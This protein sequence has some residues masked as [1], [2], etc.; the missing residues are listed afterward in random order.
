MN[1][2]LCLSRVLY[3][4]GQV[5]QTC[6]RNLR[7]H[8]WPQLPPAAVGQS[9]TDTPN[10]LLRTPRGERNLERWTVRTDILPIWEPFH[11]PREER[12]A[13]CVF[14][15]DLVCADC[16]SSIL[17][18]Q[19]W[20][21]LPFQHSGHLWSDLLSLWWHRWMELHLE[22]SRDWWLLIWKTTGGEKKHSN[23]K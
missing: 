21:G 23:C 11:I 13:Y 10:P 14:F 19:Q 15:A 8:H 16:R 3:L 22:A 2:A 20:R 1:K 18:C 7:R 6:C 4:T 12:A 5:L 9:W 17:Q